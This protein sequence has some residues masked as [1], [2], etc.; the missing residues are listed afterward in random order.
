MHPILFSHTQVIWEIGLSQTIPEGAFTLAL[1]LRTR[2]RRTSE[3][4]S[5]GCE[6]CL[7]TSGAQLYPS[8]LKKGG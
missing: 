5:F 7:P 6:R 3:F 1:L 4:G 2:V 8:L